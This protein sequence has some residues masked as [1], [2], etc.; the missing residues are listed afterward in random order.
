MKSLKEFWNKVKGIR[1]FEIYLALILGL[2]VCVLYFS[3]FVD[4]NTN[5]TKS[6]IS[7]G[8]FSS[9]EEYVDLLENKLCNVL[10]NMTGVGDVSVIIT[11]DGGFTYEYAVDSETNTT[12]SGSSETSVTVDTTILVN[13]EPLVVKVNY[14]SVKGVVIVAEGSEDF[15]VKMDIL[16][17]VQT[18]LSVDA[19][20]V[21]ILA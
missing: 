1:H 16:D 21:T 8:E 18:L 11:L 17:A 14:P 2:I 19:G 13:G 6:E 7:T 3:F 20:S 10:S 4:K 5:D 12:T 9:T 15:A